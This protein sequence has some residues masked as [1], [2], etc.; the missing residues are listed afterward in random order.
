MECTAITSHKPVGS[1]STGLA[2]MPGVTRLRSLANRKL[3]WQLVV[4]AHAPDQV[5]ESGI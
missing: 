1:E 2:A 5:R 4:Q 3:G